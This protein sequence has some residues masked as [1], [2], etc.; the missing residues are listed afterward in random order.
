MLEAGKFLAASVLLFSHLP[1]FTHIFARTPQ[2]VVFGGWVPPAPVAVQ[3]FFT[4]NGFVMLT[5]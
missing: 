3:Y 2:D 1:W 5:A 4:L